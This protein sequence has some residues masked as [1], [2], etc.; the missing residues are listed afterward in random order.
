MKNQLIDTRLLNKK[1]KKIED[2]DSASCLRVKN[3]KGRK[4]DF[5]YSRSERLFLFFFVRLIGN[6]E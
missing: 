5:Y 1:N 4:R 6:L 2:S 3:T